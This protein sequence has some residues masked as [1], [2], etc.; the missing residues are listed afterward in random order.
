MSRHPVIKAC[1][2]WSRRLHRWGAILCAVPALLVIATGLLLQLKKDA[3][4][5]QPPTMRGVGSEPVLGFDAILAAAAAVPQAELV[6]W[7]DNDRLDVRP[8]R[9]VVK[10][11]ARNHWEVQI[12][13]ETGEVLQSRYRRSDLIE[14]LHDGS[15]FG[16]AAKLWIF[17]PSG[18]ILLG[19]LLTGMYLWALPVVLRPRAR[20]RAR[21]ART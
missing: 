16:D 14:S 19:L 5:I 21:R 4:W 3:A 2:V 20:R 9:G 18:A 6:G 11:R 12:D 13:A 8:S 10:V 17:L 1:N 15:F 7:E